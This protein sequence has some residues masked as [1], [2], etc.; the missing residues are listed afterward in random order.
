MGHFAM[1]ENLDRRTDPAGRDRPWN[2]GFRNADF[3]PGA[4]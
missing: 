2:R 3:L 4:V 1:D